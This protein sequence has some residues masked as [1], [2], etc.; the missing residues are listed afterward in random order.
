M[1]KLPKD[2]PFWTSVIL[3][4]VVLVALFLATIIETLKP[5]EKP[6]VFEMVNA[7]ASQQQAAETPAET[8]PAPDIPMPEL[9]SVP[10]IAEVPKPVEAPPKPAPP[11]PTPPKPA[12]AKPKLTTIDD[13]IKQHGAPK[14]R[15]QTSQAQPRKP[16][17]APRIEVPKLVVPSN[18]S[19]S[20]NSP[21]PLTQQQM[22]ELGTYSAKLRS[23]IDAAWAKPASLAGVKVAATVIFD[24]SASGRVSNARLQPGSGNS[25]FDQ[26][27]LAAF[28]KVV[29]AGPT[30][31]GQGHSFTM[32]FRMTD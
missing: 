11:K 31:T 24:V 5:K 13:F 23:R 28:R 2:Q 6:H 17:E 21:Q 30:P 10:E 8:P 22:S 7:A 27:V 18:P 4:L 26:S 19:P 32:T 9:P 12:P 20:A 15:Q 14:P 1:M 16:V 3:H 29:S 25:A